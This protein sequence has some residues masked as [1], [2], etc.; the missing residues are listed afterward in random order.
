MK[1]FKK[2]AVCAL[3]AA[4]TTALCGGES[5]QAAD[6]QLPI[7]MYHN[8]TVDGETNSMTITQERFRE[9]MQF[10]KE[11]GYTPLLS[12]DLIDISAG[13]KAMPEKPVMITFDDGYE[14]NYTLGFPILKETGMKATISLIT[15]HIRDNAN[16][17]VP[18]S[19]TW[20]QAREMYQSGIVDIG[21][22]THML[23]NEENGGFELPGGP[24]GVQR[25]KG[26]SWMDYQTRVG[27][28]IRMSIR[29][30]QANLGD[31][32]RVRYFSYPFGATDAW[33]GQV[34][35]DNGL[36]VSTTTKSSTADI[37]N[38]LYGLPR[39]RI[40]MELPVSQL[41]QHSATATPVASKVSLGG[42]EV[43]LP[44]YQ[45]G[46]NN[47]VKLRDVAALLD[48]TAARFSVGWENGRVTVQ[49]GAQYTPDGSELAPLSQQPHSGKSMV[50]PLM[51]DGKP[52]MLAAY[53]IDGNYCFKL[54]SLG[55]ALGFR[56]DW[57]E[58]N[59]I[60]ILTMA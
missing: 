50:D 25:M 55:D 16:V 4:A 48:G 52:A 46:G 19:M 2:I 38:G 40:T 6:M 9:D 26:E 56:V 32:A 53:N 23:H 21:T 12:A 8:L 22:H 47:Y 44:A 18:T 15:S 60:L 45:I 31:N 13:A 30:I 29:T 10:L 34:L 11:Y 35:V 43:A 17:G 33:F 37:R 41:L 42:R 14:S 20:Q 24:D 59:G 27:Q 49:K 7:L 5:A 36:F 58:A 39:Y 57:D 51:V 28:D 1:K 3:L 54:R